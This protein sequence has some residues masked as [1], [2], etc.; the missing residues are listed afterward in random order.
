MDRP[1]PSARDLAL[2]LFLTA[3]RVERFLSMGISAVLFDSC[4]LNHLSGSSKSHQ[5][6]SVI[7]GLFLFW[8][9]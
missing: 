4:G 5:M 7:A 6:Q 1:Q 9:E 3:C 2:R 8:P